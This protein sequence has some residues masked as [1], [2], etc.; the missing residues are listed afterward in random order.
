[1]DNAAT[2][3]VPQKGNII[4][5]IS[6]SILHPGVLEY[7]PIPTQSSVSRISDKWFLDSVRTNIG[8]LI[9]RP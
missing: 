7:L 2:R 4:S 3:C 9:A 1:V 6:H 5:I 8:D